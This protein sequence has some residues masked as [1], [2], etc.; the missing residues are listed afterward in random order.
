MVVSGE[1]LIG[2]PECL[3]GKGPQRDCWVLEGETEMPVRGAR[4]PPRGLWGGEGQGS[5][6]TAFR[7]P[8]GRPF[9]RH[10]EASDLPL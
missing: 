1:G 5:L 10:R 3:G 8:Q 6:M 4:S 9:Q 7:L 2:I